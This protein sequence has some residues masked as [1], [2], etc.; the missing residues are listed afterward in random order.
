MLNKIGFKRGADGTMLDEKNRPVE[1]DLAIAST[2]NTSND[3]AQIISDEA[4]KLG[5]KVNVRQTDFQ[6]MVESL[7]ATFD[8]QSIII[9]LGAN[10][11]PSQGSNV[12]P[13]SGNLH[14]WHPY[15]Q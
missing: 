7:T 5:I 8:W 4:K 13:S 15:Q 12:W 9:G 11:F 14:L 3:I 6:K 2:A 10:L 1:F